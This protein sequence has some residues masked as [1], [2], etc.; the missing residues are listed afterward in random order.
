MKE[1]KGVI[2]AMI[3]PFTEQEEIAWGLLDQHVDYLIDAGVH[4]LAPCGSTGEFEALSFDEVIGVYKA[5][6]KKTAGRVPVIGGM[7]GRSTREAVRMA[8][9]AESSGLDGL[10]VL[11]PYYYGFNEEE[12]IGY[13]RDIAAATN[14]VIMLYNNP[15][16]TKVDLVPR[17]VARLSEVPNIRYIKESSADV[18]RV[19]DIL[20]VTNGKV[21]VIGGWDSI[22]LESL[23]M[24]AKGLVSG[25]SNVVPEILVK[26]YDL[27][28][29]TKYREALDY[30][31][32]VRPFLALIEDEGRLAAWIKA[33]M[34]LRGRNG[35]F[36]C[37]PYLPATKEEIGRIRSAAQRAG[38]ELP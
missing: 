30:Y 28:V 24:G 18:R 15:G 34:R 17:I 27:V 9:A 6:V 8:K 21:T 10:L 12:I 23:L 37:K 1:L 16:K 2:T 7:G 4:C 5:V 20:Q 25:G 38:I 11:P 14:L 36:P 3:T 22:T 31:D 33:G 29:Q 13:Y 26:L 19:K 32:K 35:G